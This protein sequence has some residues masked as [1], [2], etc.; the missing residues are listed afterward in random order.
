MAG[1]GCPP[2]IYPEIWDEPVTECLDEYV[3][4][5][6]ER[7]KE[8]LVRGQMEGKSLIVYLN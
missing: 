1:F 6:F 8:F 3:L 4:H 7:L 5:Y 2:R